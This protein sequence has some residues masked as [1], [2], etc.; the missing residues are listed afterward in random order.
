MRG[1]IEWWHIND[2]SLN[3]G[4]SNTQSFCSILE[5]LLKLRNREPTF[6]SQLYCSRSLRLRKVTPDAD[7]RQAVSERNNLNFKIPVL[8]WVTKY[9][10][11]WDDNRYHNQDDYFEY[12][13]YDVTEQGLGEAS[14]R[15]L[16]GIDASVFSFL[17]SSHQFTI[18]PLSVQQGLYEEPIRFV[19]IDNFWDLERLDKL[20]QRSET[21]NSWK[22]VDVEINSR[23]SGL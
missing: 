6:S 1:G 16:A 20:I 2:L 22:D 19:D 15:K 23:F 8:A 4:F 9:G 10:P 5:A 13:S 7:V 17:G 11:F 14:R 18:S 3:G 21:Y 12:Q